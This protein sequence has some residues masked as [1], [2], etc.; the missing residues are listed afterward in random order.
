MTAHSKRESPTRPAE[1]PSTGFL[2]SSVLR[3]WVVVAWRLRLREERAKRSKRASAS[4]L[5]FFSSFFF[6]VAFPFQSS[7]TL[8]SSASS[9]CPRWERNTRRQSRRRGEDEEPKERRA[10]EQ[11]TRERG[12]SRKR[13]Q[14]GNRSTSKRQ[15]GLFKLFLLLTLELLVEQQRRLVHCVPVSSRTKGNEGARSGGGGAEEGVTAE[16]KRRQ[17]ATTRR[18]RRRRRARFFSSSAFL[19]GAEVLSVR[20]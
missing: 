17:R 6:F 15:R 14:R 13:E 10:E 16:I 5:L 9:L 1:K 8:P 20:A 7:L 11:K 2:V 3:F 4:R 18:R 19:F 12:E